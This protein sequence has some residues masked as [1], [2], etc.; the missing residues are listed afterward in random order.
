MGL[1]LTWQS[2]PAIKGLK[3]SALCPQIEKKSF[4]DIKEKDVLLKREVNVDFS[5][6]EKK[7][8][9]L[10]QV[11]YLNPKLVIF[12]EIDAGLDIKKLEQVIE[13]IK[14]EFIKKNI[15]VLLV[16]HSGQILNYLKPDITNVMLDGKI[17]CQNKDFKKVLRVI[18]KYGYEKCK[19]CPVR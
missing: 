16:T 8:S 15:S 6:G 14:S 18:K 1:A 3:L 17:I 13:I 7:I 5:G 19:K 11:L 2:P 12:D 10:L 4:F 9:E